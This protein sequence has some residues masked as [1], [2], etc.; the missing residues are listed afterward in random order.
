MV[1]CDVEF[2]ALVPHREVGDEAARLLGALA[3]AEPAALRRGVDRDEHRRAV[4]RVDG[5]HSDGTP[6]ERGVGVLFARGEESIA[7]EV[8]HWHRPTRVL[9]RRM[10]L[11]RSGE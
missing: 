7:V 1:G 8:E 2:G 10:A 5:G 9:I 11:F 3:L 4:V 6:V